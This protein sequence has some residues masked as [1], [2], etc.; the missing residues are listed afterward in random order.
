MGV[1]LPASNGKPAVVARKLYHLA[2]SPY[3]SKRD[4]AYLS[5]S[6]VEVRRWPW[7]VIVLHFALASLVGVML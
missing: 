6:V 4:S 3:Q 7:V 1:K 5:S 2:S